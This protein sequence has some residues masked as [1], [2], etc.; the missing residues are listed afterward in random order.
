VY[1]EGSYRRAAMHQM[2][3]DESLRLLTMEMDSN[4][5]EPAGMADE[6]VTGEGL[7]S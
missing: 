5:A 2:I 6:A 4:N 7:L 1:A 3:D